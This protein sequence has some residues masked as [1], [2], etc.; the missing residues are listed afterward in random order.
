LLESVPAV[1]AKLAV[2][3]PLATV[4]DPGTTS[5]AVLLDSVTTAPPD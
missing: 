5:A 2:V 1:A 4:T 3:E